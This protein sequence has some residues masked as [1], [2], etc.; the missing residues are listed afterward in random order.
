MSRRAAWPASA[1]RSPWRRA[2]RA[3]AGGRA[4][5]SAQPTLLLTSSSASSGSKQTCYMRDT[6]KQEGI[7]DGEACTPKQSL[8]EASRC[9]SLQMARSVF[10]RSARSE[11][12]RPCRQ[13]P[14]RRPTLALSCRRSPQRRRRALLGDAEQRLLARARG[15]AEPGAAAR[16]RAVA[17]GRSAVRG[18]AAPRALYCGTGMSSSDMLVTRPATEDTQAACGPA[19]LPRPQPLSRDAGHSVRVQPVMPT[20]ACARAACPSLW[21]PPSSHAR[22][23]NT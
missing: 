18:A 10:A 3:H 1:T 5:S 16:A 14:Q 23:L 13:L 21:H 22:R 20:S 2:R 4:R 9:A 19:L 15:G 6:C 12:G 8:Q 17:G 11:R 7:W